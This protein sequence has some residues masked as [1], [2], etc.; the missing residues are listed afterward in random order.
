MAA[1][2]LLAFKTSSK[3]KASG[4]VTAGVPTVVFGAVTTLGDADQPLNISP[5]VHLRENGLFAKVMITATGVTGSGSVQF[6]VQVHGAKTIAGTYSVIHSTP[7]DM[8]Y[9]NAPATTGAYTGKVNFTCYVP[10]TAP[11]GFTDSTNTVQDVYQWFQVKVFETLNTVTASAYTAKVQIVSGK[12][13]GI[14]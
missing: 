7:S 1:D 12:D 2:A 11:T 13:G 6:F 14:L 10:I 4:G 5:Q 8:V 3:S 9:L